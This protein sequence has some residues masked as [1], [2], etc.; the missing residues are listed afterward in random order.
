MNGA[1]YKVN[2]D[3]HKVICQMT[4]IANFFVGEMITKM[5][6][7]SMNGGYQDVI[8]Y[9]T[10]MGSIGVLFPFE[11]KEVREFLF[12]LNKPF[13]RISTSSFTSRCT[14]E[15]RSNHFAAVITK[16]SARSLALSA[17]LLTVIFVNNLPTSNHQSKNSLQM[18]LTT[19]RQRF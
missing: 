2:I 18:N 17:Q 10:S 15:C 4:Q 6:K 19:H 14:F 1:P 12:I 3:L 9:V 5:Q 13:F 7:V 11:T 16:C 8:V